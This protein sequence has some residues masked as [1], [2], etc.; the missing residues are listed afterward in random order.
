[1]RDA[2]Q[3]IIRETIPKRN[4]PCPCKSGRKAKVCCLRAI[5]AL[6]DLPP[7]LREQVVVA[8]ILGQNSG[9]Q[10]EDQPR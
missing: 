5:K 4:D 10:C 6:R 3:P 8:R 7:A 2:M 1:M 9:A